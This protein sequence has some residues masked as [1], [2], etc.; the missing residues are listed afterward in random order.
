M[1][2]DWP[3]GWGRKGAALY[4]TGDLEGAKEAYEEGLRLD[5][6]NAGFQKDLGGVQAALEQESSGAGKTHFCPRL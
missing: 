3:K 1:K 4:G 2:P 6:N 5:P